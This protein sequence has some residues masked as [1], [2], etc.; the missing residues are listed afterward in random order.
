MKSLAS[1]AGQLNSAVIRGDI[2]KRD[3]LSYETLV[4]NG[5]TG[6]RIYGHRVQTEFHLH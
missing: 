2:C 1:K 4:G 3:I 5:K 6:S